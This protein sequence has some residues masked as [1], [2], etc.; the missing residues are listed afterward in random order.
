MS[1]KIQKYLYKLSNTNIQNSNFNLYLNKLNYWYNITG[2]SI[3][4]SVNPPYCFKNIPNGSN[5]Y[6]TN[7]EGKPEYC[8][9]LKD[10]SGCVIDPNN[11]DQQ[12]I[13]KYKNNTSKY[14]YY[15]IKKSDVSLNNPGL[16]FK[17]DADIKSDKIIKYLNLTKIA[18]NTAI[19]KD[20]D[21]MLQNGAEKY[22]TI[23]RN[24]KEI[25]KVEP[26]KLKNDNDN[27]FKKIKD[28]NDLWKL[29]ESI[30]KN[31]GKESNGIGTFINNY[32]IIDFKP[33]FNIKIKKNEDEIKNVC[34]HGIT[35][36]YEYI[37]FKRELTK[38]V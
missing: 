6:E 14:E 13:N 15:A 38:C 30:I 10:A 36:D 18:E 31:N 32:F 25:I 4:V 28:E 33:I 35:N 26:K 27:V 22:F 34:L 17:F 29:V 8:A 37:V 20:A 24:D 3:D 23:K 9:Y 12:Y 2:G 16:E 5:Y 11:K 21:N 7:N 19:D 1:Q